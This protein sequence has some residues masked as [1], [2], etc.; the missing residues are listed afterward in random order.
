MIGN[1]SGYSYAPY[2]AHRTAQNTQGTATPSPI[3]PQ[4]STA[5]TDPVN[6]PV[7]PVAPVQKT[8]SPENQFSMESLL[9]QYESDPVEMA[10]RMRIQTPAQ[11]ADESVE[12]PRLPGQKVEEEPWN[13]LGS[14]ENSTPVEEEDEEGK[15]QEEDDK[16]SPQETME[17]G[18]C[19]TCAN[20]KYQDGSDDPGVSFKMAT[21]LTPD[22][23]ATAVRG[24]E[25]EHVVREQAKASREGREVISQSVTIKTAIC[26]EC[27]TVYTA[28]G[29]TQTVT[30]AKSPETTPELTQDTPAAA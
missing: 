15:I 16:K 6:T 20:R 17:E 23:A 21:A 26:P 27:G 8:L 14:E 29:T 5:P 22:R 24:H 19:Q 10:V 9:G 7:Q 2:Y 11:E 18:E 30:K 13:L 3:S 12:L 4:S 28:G 1:L 25:M